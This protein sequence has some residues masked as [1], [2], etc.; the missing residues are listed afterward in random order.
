MPCISR[1]STS[2]ARIQRRDYLVGDFDEECKDDDYKQVVNDADRSYD[3]VRD[4]Q[5]HVADVRQIQVLL[6]DY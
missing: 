4:L 1:L 5:R 6:K 2:T 3:D